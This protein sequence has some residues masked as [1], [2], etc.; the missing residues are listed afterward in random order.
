M[1]TVPRLTFLGF[2]SSPSLHHTLKGLAKLVPF[3]VDE[4]PPT[5]FTHYGVSPRTNSNNIVNEANYQIELYQLI[6]DYAQDKSSFDKGYFGAL[7]I[8][9][10]P[11][12]Y[13][14]L[15]AFL[16]AFRSYCDRGRHHRQIGQFPDRI[17]QFLMA[18]IGGIAVSS[19]N[20]LLPKDILLS[21]LAIAFVIGYSID[22]FTSRIDRYIHK[23]VKVD[24]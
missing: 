12:A 1:K 19:F 11:V 7:T 17:S 24:T 16:Y 6:R 2:F 13:A 18:G 22:A 5:A 10:L 23:F 8:Y 4:N 15:G 21:P 14:L 3:V 9:L 20:A